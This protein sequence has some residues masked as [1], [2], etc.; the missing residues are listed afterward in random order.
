LANAN[1]LIDDPNDGPESQVP[2][3]RFGSFNSSPVPEPSSLL[4]LGTG[5]FGLA[6]PLARKF[7]FK[8]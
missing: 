3:G 8:A 1:G 4:L 5:L 7:K 6:A 2:P